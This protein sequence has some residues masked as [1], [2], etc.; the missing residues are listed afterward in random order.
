MNESLLKS[1]NT[2]PVETIESLYQSRQHG[3]G[4]V[5]LISDFE[6]RGGLDWGDVHRFLDGLLLTLLA[7]VLFVG[8]AP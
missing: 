4:L 6:V 3:R 1:A 5:R 8:K 2:S 7:P